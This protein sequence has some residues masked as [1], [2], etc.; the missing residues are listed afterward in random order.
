MGGLLAAHVG[1]RNPS[2]NIA[3]IICLSPLMG[4]PNNKKL[5]W[6]KIA[7]VEFIGD[8]LSV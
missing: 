1:I 5:E 6:D 2:L 4:F 3:G 7:A 8:K